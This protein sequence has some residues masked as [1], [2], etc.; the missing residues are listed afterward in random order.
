HA[1]ATSSYG[2]PDCHCYFDLGSL[3]ASGAFILGLPH[4]AAKLTSTWSSLSRLFTR[5]PCSFSCVHRPSY[6]VPKS[7]EHMQPWIP[8][9]LVILTL[10]GLISQ[11]RIWN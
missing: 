10:V 1:G 11:M 4:I 7:H 6:P 3:L 2:L 8:F 9:H 5:L